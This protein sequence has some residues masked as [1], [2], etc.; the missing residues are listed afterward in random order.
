MVVDLII[1]KGKFPHAPHVSQVLDASVCK[2]QLYHAAM[3][4]KQ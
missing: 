3:L 1:I 2:W 4:R